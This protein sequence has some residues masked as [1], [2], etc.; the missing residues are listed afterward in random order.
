MISVHD[1]ANGHVAEAPAISQGEYEELVR[2]GVLSS[3]GES[4][5]PPIHPSERPPLP[6][7][8]VKA[9]CV[10]NEAYDYARPSSFS[11]A[12]SIDLAGTRLLFISGTASVDEGGATVHTGD[13]RAQLWRTF[14]NIT[15]LL[16]AEGMT[17]HD[18]VRT[19]CYLR[20]IERDYDEFNEV[21]TAFYDWIGLDPLP[22][23]TAI[24]AR[25]CRSDLLVEIEAIAVRPPE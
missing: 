18:I 22:A 1:M 10:L 15:E 3:E 11:R 4:L 9:P 20:D 25:I 6:K 17:W 23:S 16:K 24:Q 21:R 13:F 2:L 7:R 8:L 19:T 5:A 12:L 14:R